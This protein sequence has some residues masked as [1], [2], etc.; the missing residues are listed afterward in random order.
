LKDG[1]RLCS[2]D[3]ESL[4]FEHWTGQTGHEARTKLINGP[5]HLVENL[6]NILALAFF[7]AL[8]F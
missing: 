2:S 8:T 3:F 4:F 6:I 1:S 7:I 5:N